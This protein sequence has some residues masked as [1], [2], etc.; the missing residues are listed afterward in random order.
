MYEEYMQNFM[1]YPGCGCQNTYD[2][3]NSNYQYGEGLDPNMFGYGYFGQN[4]NYRNM[5]TQNMNMMQ[6]NEL[7]NC[8]P[9]IYKVVYPMVKKVCMK[10]RGIANPKMIDDMVNEV[11][12]NI[13]TND[14]IELNITVNNEVRKAPNTENRTSTVENRTSTVENR[15]TSTETRDSTSENR[16]QRNNGLNDLIRIL[17]LRELLGRPGNC[18]GP[19]CNPGPRPGPGYGPRPPFPRYDIGSQT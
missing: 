4:M 9:E 10:C 6:A 14:G 5:N 12:N 2:Q 17:I 1:N 18:F 16:A 11:Y 15:G 19:N 7:E 3:Y 8:Y 13:E